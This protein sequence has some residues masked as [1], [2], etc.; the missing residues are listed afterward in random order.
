MHHY[1]NLFINCPFLL[2]AHQEYLSSGDN[3]STMTYQHFISSVTGLFDRLE[4]EK[5]AWLCPDCGPSPKVLVADGK[6]AGPTM[7]KVCFRIMKPDLVKWLRFKTHLNNALSSS[8][9]S[10]CNVQKHQLV[11]KKM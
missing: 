6:V 11:I 8:D 10:M 4:F 5:S 7:R 2:R 9:L 1:D 3:I